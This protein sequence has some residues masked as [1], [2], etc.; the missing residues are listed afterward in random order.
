MHAFAPDDPVTLV[1][2]TQATGFGPPPFFA[3]QPTTDLA[4]S[5]IDAACAE[6]GH[7]APSICLLPYELTGRGIDML[8]EIGHAYVSLAHGEGWALGAFDAA[9]RGTPVTM[10]AWGGHRD[11]LDGDWPGAVACR[12]TSVPVWPPYHPSLWPPQR[13]ATPDFA[14]A[15]ASLRRAFATPEAAAPAATRIQEEIA[16]RY[17]EPVV[18]REYLAAIHG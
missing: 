1:I 7:A 15:V 11:Y 16:N 14:A 3:L 10:T 13:W 5:A 18:T 9:T 2:K 6:A 8:H 12:L 17:A 4:Q